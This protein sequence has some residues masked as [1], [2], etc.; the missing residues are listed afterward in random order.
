MGLSSDY[1]LVKG[2]SRALA[3]LWV[4]GQAGLILGVA[5][6][7]AAPCGWLAGSFGPALLA[8][9][10]SALLTVGSVCLKSYARKRA[11]TFENW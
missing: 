3:V 1:A 10:A 11:G 2:R 7:V 5:G 4:G 9:A 8:F 6:L